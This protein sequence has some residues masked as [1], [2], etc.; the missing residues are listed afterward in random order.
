MSELKLQC[1]FEGKYQGRCTD[2]AYCR[3]RFTG[4]NGVVYERDLCKM[5]AVGIAKALNKGW[6]KVIKVHK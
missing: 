2:D 3:I 5:H 6:Y 1:E 4:A